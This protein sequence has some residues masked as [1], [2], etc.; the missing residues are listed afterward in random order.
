MKAVFLDRKTFIYEVNFSAITQ[1]VNELIFYPL[2]DHKEIIKRSIDADIIITNKV[3]LTA[4]T[5]KKLPNLK[6]ICI[7]ATGM[8]NVDLAAAK[9]LNIAVMNVAGYSRQSVSQYVFAQILEYYTNINQ[10]NAN[11]LDGKWQTSD[12]F[13]IHSNQF[14][15]IANKKIGI[16]GYGDLGKKVAHIAN[17]FEMEVLI[18]ERPN[19]KPIR[20]GRLP[21]YEVL[22]QADII[23]LH[24]PLT[25][26]TEHLISEQA[27][28][29][30]QPHALLINT[31]RGPV[32]DEDAL[33]LALKNKQIAG[34]I[35]DVLG[36]EPPP[37]DHPL[38]NANLPNLKITAHIAW[39]SA[40]AQQRLI[41]LIG[42]NIKQFI[43]AK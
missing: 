8:N 15:E 6:L 36:I 4:E 43:A 24:C 28:N 39:A 10:Q 16:I 14:S 35:L 41:N 9:A 22:T 25:P 2:T 42:E 37:K 21:L 1:Q 20:E 5:L 3:M 34:A 19:I 33:L 32:I 40:Q 7:A 26:E 23:S 31:A 30:M 11:T 27:L 38:L 17:A 29:L 13:C 18:A 12:T